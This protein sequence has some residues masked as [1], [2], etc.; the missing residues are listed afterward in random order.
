MTSVEC[1]EDGGCYLKYHPCIIELT[2]FRSDHCENTCIPYQVP[3]WRPISPDPKD[4]GYLLT[5]LPPG[6][7]DRHFTGDMFKRIFLKENISISNK[8]S[9]KCVLWVN[10][11]YVRIG[12]ESGLARS[13]RQAIIWA[14]ADQVHWRIYAAL[15]GEE[16]IKVIRMSRKGGDLEDSERPMTFKILPTVFNSKPSEVIGNE[17]CIEVVG[18]IGNVR[19]SLGGR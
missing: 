9:L 1:V 3:V 16:L 15:R 8:I 13:R 7:N 11:Q 4:R 18:S 2:H 10:I 14:Y 17:K 12:S 6:Q 5:H 19:W